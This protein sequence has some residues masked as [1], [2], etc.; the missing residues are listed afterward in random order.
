MFPLTPYSD[1]N[2]YHY[3]G[4]EFEQVANLLDY[5]WRWYDPVIGRWNGV[6]PLAELAPHLTPYRY[7]FNNPLRY[8]DPDGLFEEDP[9]Y[10]RRGKKIGDDGKEK[11]RAYIVTGRKARDVR[12]ATNRG[13]NYS[14]SL[15]GINVF[16]VPTGGVMDDV[17]RSVKDTETSG[18][19]QGGHSLYGADNGI[20]WDEGPEPHVR[21]RHPDGTPAEVAATISPF[22]VGGVSLVYANWN[23]VE[24]Y[25]HTHPDVNVE[26]VPLGSHFPSPS[27][28]SF[29][30][31]MQSRGFTGSPFLIGA[32]TYRVTFYSDRGRE[33][34]IPFKTFKRIG[35]G[36]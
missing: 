29:Q 28:L 17:I 36:Q 35:L 1:D 27:D 10:D 8:I 4:K 23:N 16:K 13:E 3:N 2:R 20:R 18:R 32:R 7:G 11:G 25:W 22:T 6:D 5:G 30:G 15:E 21:S 24:F 31:T 9:I 14:G 19:E 34:T 26:G 33:L 12:R